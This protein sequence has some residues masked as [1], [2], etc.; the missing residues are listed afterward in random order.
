MSAGLLQMHGETSVIKHL[1]PP[2]KIM[3]DE[4]VVCEKLPEGN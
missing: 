3:G 1:Y 4:E 2:R